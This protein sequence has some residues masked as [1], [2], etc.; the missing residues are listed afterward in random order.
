MDFLKQYDELKQERAKLGV[1]PLPLSVKQTEDLIKELV[2]NPNEELLTLL[3]DRVN[4]GVDDAALIKAQ[5]LDKIVKKE[6][7]CSA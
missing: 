3:E 2:E 5:F 1:P 7:T 6:I 4:P